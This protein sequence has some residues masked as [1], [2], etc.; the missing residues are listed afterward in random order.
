[1]ATFIGIGD[2][3]LTNSKEKNR[4]GLSNYIE[5]HDDMVR[6]EVFRVLRYAKSQG[7][8]DIL[9]YGD[10]CC[11]TRMSYEAQLAMLK[12][13]RLPFQFHIIPGNHDLVF[14]KQEVPEGEEE[15]EHHSLQVLRELELPNV[16][17]YMEPETVKF[18]KARVR[19]LP[20]PH[21]DFD[22]RALNVAHLD[23]R[24]AKSD[25]GRVQ[26]GDHL[27]DSHAVIVSGHIHTNQVVR[28]TYLVGTLYQVSFG[29]KR[30][31]FFH[32]IEFNSVND[33]EITSI[34]FEPEY[35]LHNVKI[36]CKEDL[37]KV[38][39]SP[40]DLVKLVIAKG[41]DVQPADWQDL[42]SVKIMPE[43]Q[44]LVE[45]AH[46]LQDGAELQ[47]DL[48]HFFKAWL[49]AQNIDEDLKKQATRLR[50]LTLKRRTK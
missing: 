31:K 8:R 47:F 19:F 46:G 12:I 38:P 15:E 3:H 10:L 22:V 14:D 43:A 24:G 32:H 41:A 7:I 49:E 50:A 9:L 39:K 37:A 36:T 48:D 5:D 29:E 34:P 25:T 20:W 30:P 16:T 18:G 28:N 6:R 42:T 35:N 11:G 2:L 27:P 33:Y 44:E 26:D 21:D 13:L 4:G 40:K 17:I 23:F 45:I 1:M